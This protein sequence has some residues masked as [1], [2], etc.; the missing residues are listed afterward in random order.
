MQVGSLQLQ[1]VL[2]LIEE[3]YSDLM[4]KILILEGFFCNKVGCGS[5]CMINPKT[6][7]NIYNLSRSIAISSLFINFQIK[8]KEKARHQVH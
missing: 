3:T 4:L 1:G 2:K 5:C 8:D 6:G 7:V